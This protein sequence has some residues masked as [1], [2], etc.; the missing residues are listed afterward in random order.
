MIPVTFFS[1]SRPFLR[2]PNLW[3]F[4][5]VEERSD[6]APSHSGFPALTPPS[7]FR[8]FADPCDTVFPVVLMC[9]LSLYLYIPLISGS[10]KPWAK[11]MCWEEREP[12]LSQAFL[13]TEGV[14]EGWSKFEAVPIRLHF[15]GGMNRPAWKL[16]E[17]VRNFVLDSL[18]LGL[19]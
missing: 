14:S 4:V 16:N 17:V 15:A 18:I 7:S 3:R 2:S 5:P 11:K 8:G 10:A 1:F 13:W 12:Q 6:S 19:C 9:S